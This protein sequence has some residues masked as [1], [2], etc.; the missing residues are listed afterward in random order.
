MLC[1]RPTLAR[2][3]RLPSL[4][5]L[6]QIAHD[7]ARTASRSGLLLSRGAIDQYVDLSTAPRSINQSVIDGAELSVSK[8]ERQA[9]SVEHQPSQATEERIRLFSDRYGA[10]AFEELLQLFALPCVTYAEIAKRFGVT[11]ERVRQ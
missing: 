5:T 11:R 10:R 9:P 8:L 4:I 6:R 2:Y 7:K 1:R 3:A